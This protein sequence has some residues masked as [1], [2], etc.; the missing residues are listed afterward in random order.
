MNTKL[1]WVMFLTLA[2]A[3]SFVSAAEQV[4]SETPIEGVNP[5]GNYN[6]GGI[7][8][9]SQPVVNI[10]P[11]D[12]SVQFNLV[13]PGDNQVFQTTNTVN[14]EFNFVATK[15]D[16]HDGDYISCSVIIMNEDATEAVELD[17]LL[18]EATGAGTAQ[19][20][21]TT[22][23]QYK[24]KVV[25]SNNRGQSWNSIDSPFSI[26][27]VAPLAPE[28]PS[29]VVNNPVVSSNDNEGNGRRRASLPL[30]PLSTT[31]GT[32][33]QT[34]QSSK[35]SGSNGFSAITGAVVGLFGKKGALG[36]GIFLVVV[37]LVALVVYNRAFLGIVKAK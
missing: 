19:Y 5:S 23:G 14:V 26:V 15:Y 10:A 9:G 8:V 1:V 35:D 37:G 36:I 6:Q 21:F 12:P 3:L 18:N 16:F 31:P 30:T 33:N 25:C 7:L 24:W 29:V 17:A 32:G 4:I 11:N 28:E 34:S 2:L 22:S 13:S 27:F 20:L